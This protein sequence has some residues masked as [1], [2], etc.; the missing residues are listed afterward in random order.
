ML[1]TQLAVHGVDASMIG[2]EITETAL[3][4]DSEQVVGNLDYLRRKNIEVY[5]DDFGTGYSS[6]SFLKRYPIDGLKVD[7]SFVD[8]VVTQADDQ[9]LTSAVISI[10]HALG[11]TVLAEGVETEQQKDALIARKCH[12][13]QG[14]LFSRPLSVAKLC[15]YLADARAQR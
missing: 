5:V 9:A 11:I 15:D 13:A 6:L 12:M 8:G 10:A 1:E 4:S 14:Y 3:I 7:R 2:I